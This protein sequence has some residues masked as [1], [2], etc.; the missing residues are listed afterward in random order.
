MPSTSL[1]LLDR[2]R[3]DADSHAWTRL[4][5]IYT[6]WL[7]DL[8]Q[9]AE[10]SIDDRDDLRQDVLAVMCR[11]IADFEHNGHIG[12]FR[13]WLR[14]ITMNR[15]RNYWRQRQNRANRFVSAELEVFPDRLRD[16]E[17]IW[18][19][20]HDQFVMQELL[21]KAESSFTESTWKAFCLQVLH[22]WEAARVADELGISVNAA[23]IAKSRILQH[24][25][26]E[27]AGILDDI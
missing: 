4:V 5:N 6:P 19:R 9:R 10:I 27:A 14:N 22:G 16:L 23:L 8:L 26:H 12:A 2:V 24:L 13:R 18:D 7:D 1:S 11:E 21:K 15:L 25:R 20:E 3:Y 17:A